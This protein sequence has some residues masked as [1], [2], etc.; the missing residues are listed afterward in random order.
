MYD[1]GEADKAVSPARTLALVISALLGNSVMT[2][3]F[4]LLNLLK[5]WKPVV[6]TWE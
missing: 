1:L 2:R 4:S 5:F 3:H 6:I